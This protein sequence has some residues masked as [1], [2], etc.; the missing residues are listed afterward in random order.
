M[1]TGA[2]RAA[3]HAKHYEQP[4]DMAEPDGTPSWITR[5]RNFAVAVSNVKPGAVLER[6]DNPDESMLLLAP[7]VAA[8]IE[9]NG[10]RAKSAGD[11]LSILPPGASLVTARTTGLVARIFSCKAEDIL[12]RA[13]N[14]ATY[15]DGAPEVAPIAPWPDPVGGFKLRHYPMERYDSPDPSPLKMRVF[16]STNLMVNIFLPW[17][18]R[19]DETKLSPHWH[20]DFEQISLGLQGSFVHHLRYPWISDKTAWRDD[21]HEHH[22]SPSVLVIPARVVHTSQ[23]I[24][25]GV[26]RLV[27]VFGPPRADFSL[28]PGFVLNADDYPVPPSLRQ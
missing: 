6:R 12:A 17:T 23:D 28:K 24:G 25:E 9:A 20:D 10:E 19:R 3:T 13:K 16:R 21:E 15:A 18:K 5:A 27:D 22:D 2:L 26:T 4:P 8:D 1:S 7:G 11:S 14:M